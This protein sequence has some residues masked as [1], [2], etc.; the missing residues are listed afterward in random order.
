VNRWPK[1]KDAPR[2]LAGARVEIL[3]LLDAGHTPFILNPGTK[4]QFLLAGR[5]IYDRPSSS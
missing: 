3:T 2:W 1:I 4:N 5:L